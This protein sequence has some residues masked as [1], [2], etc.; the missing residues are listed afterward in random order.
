MTTS[1]KRPDGGKLNHEAIEA[2]R[3]AAPSR[4]R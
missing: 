2:V 4:Y 1:T 3:E